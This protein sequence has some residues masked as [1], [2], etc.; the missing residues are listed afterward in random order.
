MP[1][2]YGALPIHLLA[3]RPLQSPLVQCLTL[4]GLGATVFSSQY[5]DVINVTLHLEA[6]ITTH[7][8]PLFLFFEHDLFFLISVVFFSYTL[9]V[10]FLHPLRLCGLGLKRAALPQSLPHISGPMLA[11]VTYRVSNTTS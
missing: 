4:P 1:L 7:W 11:L 2:Q 3:C 8:H 5:A 9:H 10:L 6:L